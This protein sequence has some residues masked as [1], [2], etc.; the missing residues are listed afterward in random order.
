M[1]FPDSFVEEVRRAADIVRYISE[2]V[3]L[4]KMGTSWKGLCPFHQEKTPSFNVRTEPPVF[5]CFGCG[6]GGDVFKFVMLRERV[7]F[8]EAVEMVARR[9]GV[10]IPETRRFDA[11][12]DRKEREELRALLAAAAEHFTRNLWT[13]PGTQARE[14]LLGR[15]F[16]KETLETIRAGAAPD[17]WSDLVD[18]LRRRFAP[19]KLLKAGL[20][21][22]RQDKSGHYDRFR[23]RA[24]FPI[25]DE[26][27]HVVGFGARSLDGSEPKYLN[28]PETPVYSKSRVLYGLSWAKEP[29]RTDGHVV[30]MEGYLDVA[31]AI[32]GGVGSAVATCGTALTSGHARLLRRFA[33]RVLVNFDQDAAGRKAVLKSLEVL[34]EEGLEVRVVTLPE[35]HDPDSFIREKD[36]EAYKERLAAAPPAMEWLIGR[37]AEDNDTSTPQ[38]K[39][40]YLSA[41]LPALT[42]IDSAVERAAW[43]PRVVEAGHLDPGAA[44]QELR[45]ALSLR[46]EPT[47]VTT[48]APKRASGRLLP[49]ERW[50]LSLVMRGAAG[51]AEA[52]ARLEEGDIEGLRSATILLTARQLSA[53]DGGLTPAGLTAAL[54]SEDDQRLL[55]EIAVE[56]P[57]VDTARAEDCT[58][59]LRRL[60]LKRQLTQIQAEMGRVGG[61]EAAAL[62]H[63]KVEITRQMA[64]L[65]KK[66]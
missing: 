37:A 29:I 7:G 30:L 40:T 49:A 43:V 34:A 38:G 42:R 66:A 9:F 14:Y 51:V 35:G 45:K 53:S 61:A 60:R 27:G 17:S 41:L 52:L 6:E 12:P 46:T 64:N 23:N 50:L 65:E 25:L 26:A 47:A 33:P 15:D 28:S 48:P 63:Q 62:L 32:E 4:K 1:A 55:R 3:P 19:E 18:A 20:V 8:P 44:E 5:H 16:R 13:A 21:L 10:P 2:Q 57:V 59:E 54:A 39:A 31:R 36:G 24:V 11:G 56:G 58:R 22:E